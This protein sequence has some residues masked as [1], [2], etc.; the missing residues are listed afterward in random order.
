MVIDGVTPVAVI[1]RQLDEVLT[2]CGDVMQ[3]PPFVLDPGDRQLSE[4][5]LN[6]FEQ[7]FMSHHLGY[8]LP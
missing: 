3:R 1:L 7:F 4:A 6:A 8:Q 2:R 5:E